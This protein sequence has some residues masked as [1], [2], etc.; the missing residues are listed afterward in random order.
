MDIKNIAV[1]GAGLMGAGIAQVAAVAGYNVVMRDIEDRF[2]ENGMAIIKKNLQRDVDKERLTAAQMEEIL[3]RL[4]A[5]LD[6]KASVAEADVVIEVIIEDMEIKKKFFAE[7]VPLLKPEAFICSN[8]SGLSITEMAAATDRPEKF[9]GM[10]FFNP[11][12]VMKLVELI[13]GMATSDEAFELAKEMAVKMGKTV[14]EVNESPGFAVNRI[15]VPMMN[16]AIFALMEGVASAEDIDT[17][18]KLGAN[19]PIG[20]LALADLVGLDTLLKVLDGLYK[21]FGDPKYRACPL[22]RKMV[23]AKYY[24]RKSGKGFYDYTK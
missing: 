3:G 19:H 10:H 18:M 4:T 22:L 21:D 2:I 20:P 11:V 14:I 16:E 6:L 13:R 7:M 5:T 12:P 23:R 17:G 1:M 15:L 8:T 9:V 24:G